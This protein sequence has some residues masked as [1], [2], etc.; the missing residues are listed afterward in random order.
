MGKVREIVR[1]V[2]IFLVP[3]QLAA[4]I[5][6]AATIKNSS[7]PERGQEMSSIT[8]LP[9]WFAAPCPHRSPGSERTTSEFAS[10][11][12]TG[13]ASFAS[14]FI[15]IMGILNI[16]SILHNLFD[17]IPG[18]KEQS[19]LSSRYQR[20]HVIDDN[21]KEK[22]PSL[23]IPGVHQTLIHFNTIITAY[24]SATFI[25]LI[26]GLIFGIGKVWGFFG[27]FH[28]IMEVFIVAALCH[29][30][31]KR[32]IVSI[33]IILVYSVVV[34]GALSLILDFILPV[35]FFIVAF[36]STS[37]FTRL[38]NV[39]YLVFASLVHLIG[40][41]VSAVGNDSE[42]STIIFQSSYF[43]AFPIYAIYV[44]YSQKTL[45]P[46]QGADITVWDLILLFSWGA[47]ASLVTTLI[48][49]KDLSCTINIL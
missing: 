38:E 13:V 17:L 49:I 11:I 40:N 19:L 39:G 8:G 15:K 10:A 23:K 47:T 29:R 36:E 44:H 33:L 42:S 16:K 43:I 30:S 7:W 20:Y 26:A 28:N 35:L 21:S 46:H 5:Y 41:V 14:I 3:L 48:G 45:E 6:L 24:V 25:A 31:N 4:A 2:G 12:V 32:Y 9:I 22:R 18:K 34:T 1:V 27:I 37:E